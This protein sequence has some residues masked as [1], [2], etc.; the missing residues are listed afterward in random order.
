MPQETITLC[1]FPFHATNNINVVAVLT[2]EVD[3]TVATLNSVS[4]I[5]LFRDIEAHLL[6]WFMKVKIIS[7]QSWHYS[8][9]DIVYLWVTLTY[10]EQISRCNSTRRNISSISGSGKR[11]FYFR[12]GLFLLWDPNHLASIGY[13]RA[14]FSEDKN[15]RRLSCASTPAYWLRGAWVRTGTT[16]P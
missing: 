5:L 7:E 10:L 1:I 2:S 3:A 13:K 11:F 6:Q 14:L 16:L 4:W 8:V 9:I 12:L 15:A